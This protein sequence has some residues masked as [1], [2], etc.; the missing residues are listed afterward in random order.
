MGKNWW[1]EKENC[2][3]G[4]MLGL[5]EL[6]FIAL[7]IIVIANV[8]LNKNKNR[9]HKR[10]GKVN[11]RHEWAIPDKY[12]NLES[13]QYALRKAGLEASNLIVG[14]DYTK[15]NLH[16]GYQTFGGRS[17]HSLEVKNPY[18]CV[19]EVM[20]RVLEEFDEDS[21]IPAFGFGDIT[22]TNKSCFPFYP[23]RPCHSFQDV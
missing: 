2:G 22:T 7:I 4:S 18:Q 23:D 14:V 6:G 8:F 5:F 17:L 13:V 12:E 19:I 21:L 3:T 20:G 1:I 16:N 10:R 11:K 15:S 9:N